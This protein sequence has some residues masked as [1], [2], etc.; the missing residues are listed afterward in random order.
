M[1]GPIDVTVFWVASGNLAVAWWA[2]NRTDRL[3]FGGIGLFLLGAWF[4]GGRA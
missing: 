2:D 4:L 1:L 3:T